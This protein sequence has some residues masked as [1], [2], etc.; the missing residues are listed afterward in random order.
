MDRIE[1]IRQLKDGWLDGAGLAPRSDQLDWF[2]AAFERHYPDVLPLPRIHPTESGD[3]QA[4]WSLAHDE[5]AI[6]NDLA[7]RRLR[8]RNFSRD[9]DSCAGATR[10][11]PHPGE[12]D[13]R[14][15]PAG[16]SRPQPGARRPSR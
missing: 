16:A 6:E 10:A 12:K 7:S 2:V 5:I 8:R 9:R 1:E 13:R 4:E 11:R 14:L 3:F 15:W